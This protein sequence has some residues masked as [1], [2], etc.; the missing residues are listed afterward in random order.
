MTRLDGKTAIVTGASCGIGLAIAERLSVE[1]G[2]G[3]FRAT[4]RITV[5]VD[6]ADKPVRVAD[7]VSVLVP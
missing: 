3:G 7:T 1:R 4:T 2:G 5:E 6:N